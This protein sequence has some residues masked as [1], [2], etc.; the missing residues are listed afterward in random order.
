MSFV[1][2]I[3]KNYKQVLSN[4]YE[5]NRSNFVNSIRSILGQQSIHVDIWINLKMNINSGIVSLN[6]IMN[7]SYSFDKIFIFTQF[8]IE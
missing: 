7:N 2:S 8:S 4:R 5:M 6:S 1:L 3:D